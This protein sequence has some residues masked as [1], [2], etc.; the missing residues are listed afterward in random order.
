M[1]TVSRLAKE[2]VV[3]LR[4]TEADPQLSIFLQ[5]RNHLDE[6]IHQVQDL[7]AQSLDKKPSLEAVAEQVYMSSRNLTRLFKQT[8]GIT[9]GAY[10]DKLRVERA[11]QLFAEGQKVDAV[12]AACGLQSPN[13]LRQLL[14]KY[15]GVLPGDVQ[16]MAG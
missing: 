14:K 9:I 10:L 13:R 5:Y 16:T 6:R 1:W 12:T 7:L 11:L 2:V 15:Q 4:R 3:F 8:T